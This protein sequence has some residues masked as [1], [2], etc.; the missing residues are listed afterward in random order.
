MTVANTRHSRGSFNIELQLVT[1][2]VSLIVSRHSQ[3]T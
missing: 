1:G 3:P 2:E